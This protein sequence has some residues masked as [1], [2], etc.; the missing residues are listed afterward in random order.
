MIDGLE[1]FFEGRHRGVAE[2]LVHFA[3]SQMGAFATA[4][5]DD[6][7][8]AQ[9]PEAVRL[10]GRAGWLQPQDSRTLCLFREAVAAVSPL[11]DAVF[12]IQGLA[13]VPSVS[14]THLTLPT[15]PYV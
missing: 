4:H 12:A 10:M 8:R 7:A 6:E 5:D 9:T 14:Y 13:S 11:A 1:A 2:E 3:R 15:T